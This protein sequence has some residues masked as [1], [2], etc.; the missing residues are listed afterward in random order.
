[1]AKVTGPLMSMDARGKFG[2]SLVFSAWKG[3]NVARQLVTP[4]NPQSVNQ[5]TARNAMRVA[6]TL[7]RACSMRATKR[8][9]ETMTDKEALAAT[10]PSG[11]AWNGHLTR[12]LIGA[13]A[14]H[15]TTARAAYAAL[16]SGEKTAWT[17]AAAAMTPAITDVAQAS[18]AGG[19]AAPISAGEVHFLGQ[20]GIY[21]AGIAD[22]PPGATPPAY[23]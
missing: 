13:G 23:A 14:L 22:T 3:R 20:Y 2:G 7:Q 21:Y 15:Y 16:S 5:T 17:D 12:S 9:G 18:A 1:M 6:A 19:S 11:Q 10:A 8:A 4:A